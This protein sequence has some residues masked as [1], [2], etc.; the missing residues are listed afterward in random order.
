[1]TGFPMASLWEC[2][3]SQGNL[4]WLLAMGFKR[5]AFYVKKKYLKAFEELFNVFTLFFFLTES[6][7][8]QFMVTETT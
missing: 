5:G 4:I 6:C 2:P 1:M 8:I 7:A 3:A